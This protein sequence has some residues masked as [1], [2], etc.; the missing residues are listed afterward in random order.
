MPART[1]YNRKTTR[2]FK[3]R[4]NKSVK[5]YRPPLSKKIHYFKRTYMVDYSV[6]DTLTN[7]ASMFRL[8]DLPSYT[9]FTNLFDQFRITGVKINFIFDKNTSLI[10]LSPT[11]VH[12]PNIP[13][14]VWVYD[15]D[16]A[17][18]LANMTDYEQY[19]SFKC[20]QLIRP[21][22]L[23]IR[24]KPSM[25]AYAGAAWN[26]YM[27]GSNKVWIDCSTPGVEYYGIKWATS[28]EM[29]GGVGANF[30]GTLRVF[31][32]VYIQCRDTR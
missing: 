16:D 28:G 4:F 21:I 10:S 27:Q 3:R 12:N 26:G 6:N 31:Y 15:F 24:P 2:R 14:L 17:S 5:L 18:A 22:R 20:K 30:N 13:N 7:Y 19:E 11:E 32:T 25:A 29:G 9:E 8:N 23:F 1:K